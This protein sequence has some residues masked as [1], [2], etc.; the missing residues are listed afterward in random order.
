MADY[1]ETIVISMGGSL[2]IPDQIDV[3]FIT[4]MKELVRHF[5]DEGYQIFLVLGGGKTCRNYQAAARTFSNV[6]D[7]DLDWIGITSIRLNAE[8]FLRIM[9]DI[10]VHPKV[11]ER[12]Q[13]AKGV[14]EPVVIV[15]AYEPGCSSD[16]DAIEMARVVGANRVINFS[17]VSHVYSEDPK[18]NPDA[19]RYDT[20]SWDQYRSIIPDTWTPG[21]STPFDPVG[22]RLAEESGITVAILGASVENLEAYLK[23]HDFD[24]TIIS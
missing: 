9:S 18:Q 13:D 6:T 12:W 24:G 3:A 4:R 15:G 1:R 5:N 20:L 8:L 14:D 17:N 23:G 21:L 16:T 22:A 10:D 11:I 7:T 2:V 19:I